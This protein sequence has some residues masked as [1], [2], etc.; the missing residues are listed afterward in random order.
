MQVILFDSYCVQIVPVSNRGAGADEIF[1]LR[2]LV[3]QNQEGI[4]KALIVQGVSNSV[5][6]I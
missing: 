2:I 4:V 6:A 1:M 5:I 3:T